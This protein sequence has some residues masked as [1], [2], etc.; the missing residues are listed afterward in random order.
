MTVVITHFPSPYQ[1]ELFDEIERQQAGAIKV[2]YLFRRDS[3]RGWKPATMAHPHD[4]LDPHDVGAGTIAQVVDAEFVVFNYYNDGRA[5]RLIRARSAAGRPWCFWGERP[6]YRFP[7][8]ARLARLGRLAP[9]HGGDQ[10]IWGIGNWAVD[11]YRMEFG[12]GRPYLNFPYYSNLDRFQ[13]ASPIFATDHFTFVFSGALSHRKGVDVLARAYKR[14]AAEFAR[15]RLKVMGDGELA[16]QLR[17]LLSTD[18]RVEWLGFKDWS[19]LPAIYATGH[20]LC[21]PSR[22]DGWGM[23]V[24]E[25]LASGLPVIATDRTGAA[26]DL[27]R[28][29]SN[30]WLIPAADEAALYR[31]MREAA[32]LDGGRWHTMSRNARASVA[33]HSLADGARRFIDGVAAA[34]ALEHAEA[35]RRR[36]GGR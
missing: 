4:Y 13:Q 9:L 10:P 25:G 21:V 18:D 30:G 32:S 15:V 1:V 28:P 23:V 35:G 34:P 11:A 5:S 14:L 19:E 20:A 36:G 3:D 31:A 17:S 6:G 33:G 26:L 24:P 2:L 7:W 27:L 16:P 8:L 12:N 29:G 22:H